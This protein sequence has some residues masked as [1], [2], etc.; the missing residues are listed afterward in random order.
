[1][2][3]ADPTRDLNREP[4]QEKNSFKSVLLNKVESLNDSH[5]NHYN[6]KMP[7]NSGES[8]DTINLSNEDRERIYAMWKFS[9]IFKLFKKRLAH[10]YLKTKLT[11]LWKPSEP[12]TLVDL[13]N[14]YYI[15]KFT[16]PDNMQKALH[17]GPWF[18]TGD[19]LSVRHWEPNFIPEKATQTHRAIWIRLPHLPTEFY[20]KSILKR[21]GHKLGT[22][23]KID[24]CTTTALRGRYARIC[25][26][27]P[28]DAPV[29]THINI[30]NHKQKVIY[31]GGRRFCALGV[32]SLGTLKKTAHC[33]PPHTLISMM[34]T[35][36][37]PASPSLF[38][39]M[40]NSHLRQKKNRPQSL[41]LP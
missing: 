36:R 18:V 23:L 31:E 14:D 41:P 25:I 30:E 16:N 24:T 9:V 28:L 13:G 20:D 4:N 33:K 37:Q 10:N 40:T 3:I 27:I 12:L 32:A 17:G 26:Q 35:R 34:Y 2:E 22:L 7:L 5:L 19:F 39:R 8:E 1:M 15:A 11:D 38:R 6:G 21:T 29:K